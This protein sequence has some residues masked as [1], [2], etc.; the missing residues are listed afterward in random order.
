M[1]AEANERDFFTKNGVKYV[2]AADG[3][4]IVHH[5]SW[6]KS[7][8]ELLMK[9]K[10]WGHMSDKNWIP[11]IEEEFSRDFNGTDFVHGYQYTILDEPFSNI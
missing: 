5:Y 7:K 11:L 9:V 6:A 1:N 3:E 8:E 2:R 4:P 10:N